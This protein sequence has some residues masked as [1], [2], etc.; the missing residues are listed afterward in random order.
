MGILYKSDIEELKVY[1]IEYN[2]LCDLAGQIISDDTL[3]RRET[4]L[5]N[6]CELLYQHNLDFSE[7]INSGLDCVELSTRDINGNNKKKFMKLLNI[8]LDNIRKYEHPEFKKNNNIKEIQPEK[9][10]IDSVV[11]PT[12]ETIVEETIVEETIVEETIVENSVHPIIEET[13]TITREEYDYFISL[14]NEKQ[15]TFDI[16][17]TTN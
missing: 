3:K 16:K 11:E 2:T 15:R 9:L 5:D 1:L 14:K 12:K 17:N 8:T 6:I 4:A 7:E 10:I 13:V